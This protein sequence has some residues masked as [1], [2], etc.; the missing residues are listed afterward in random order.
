MKKTIVFAIVLALVFAIAAPAFAEGASITSKFGIENGKFKYTAAGEDKAKTVELENVLVLTV[1]I[2]A[3]SNAAS[4]VVNVKYNQ[5]ELTYAGYEAKGFGTSVVNEP[6]GSA[7]TAGVVKLAGAG[8]DEITDATTL[9]K[10]A[11]TFDA[12]AMA[13]KTTKAEVE[14]PELLNGDG[15]EVTVASA[16]GAEY[17]F[18][19]VAEPSTVPSTVPSTQPSTVPSTQPSGVVTPSESATTSE[20]GN[21]PAKTGAASLAAVAVISVVAGL[22]AIALR[23]DA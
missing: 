7:G 3:D 14:C 11:F 5:D 17:T 2:T 13:G 15:E 1:D 19:A 16:T 23:K 18:A 22:G 8:T 21:I 4:G 9:I 6:T 12:A 20:S 10:V